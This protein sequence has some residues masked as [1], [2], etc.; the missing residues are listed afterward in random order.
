[1]KRLA[2]VDLES[3]RR[4][5]LQPF[6]ALRAALFALRA[7]GTL[8]CLLL[9]A[10]AY[11]ECFTTVTADETPSP[12]PPWLENATDA[13][14][15]ISN[16]ERVHRQAA[17]SHETANAVC[18]EWDGPA[19]RCTCYQF[20]GLF[21]ECANTGLAAL[22]GSLRATTS[23]IKSFTVYHLQEDVRILPDRLF[24]NASLE[25]LQFAYTNLEN[26]SADTFSGLEG[27]L[28]ALSIGNSQLRAVPQAALSGL[29]ALES[30]DLES[31]AVVDVENY[32][33]YGLPLVSLNMQGNSIVSLLEYAFGGLENSL[34]ELS[35][36]NNRLEQ[37][38][39]IALRRLRK[40][41][42]LKLV[43]N[44]VSFHL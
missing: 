41:R 42:S 3:A 7:P 6:R 44:L 2:K 16:A 36:I 23:P 32:A 10:V 19:A 14:E 29:K 12:T 33:F 24:G 25:K 34:E 17:A 18:P 35:L 28:R 8:V 22:V 11:C 31:N 1:M 9:F 20:D 30:L 15:I 37:F 27:S 40:L 21:I 4:V 43:S 5:P 38:P 39:L 13:S 26:L